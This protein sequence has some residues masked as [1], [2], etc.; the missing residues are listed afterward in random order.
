MSMGRVSSNGVK[1][2]IGQ[3]CSDFKLPTVGAEA[4]PRFTAAGHADALVTLV[5]VLEQ[6]AEDRRQRRI[7]RIRRASRLPVG[8]TWDTFEHDRVPVALRQQLD[9]LADGSFVERGVNALAF[10]EGYNRDDCASTLHLR[11]W[12]EGIRQDL[13]DRGAV[14][15]RPQPEDGQAAEELTERQKMI[16]ALGERLAG[17]VPALEDDRSPEQHARWLLANMLDWHRREDKAVWW[18]FFRLR[19]SSVEELMDERQAVAGLKFVDQVEAPGRLPVHRYSFPVQETTLRGGETLHMPGG[20]PAG[21]LVSIDVPN[22]TVDIKKRGKTADIHP[23]AVFANDIVRS[24]VLKDALVRIGKHVADNGIAGAGSYGAARDLLLREPPRLDG[25]AVRRP[26]ETPL[27]AA[28][29]IASRGSFGVLPIQGTARG[30]QDLHRGK[31]DLR[32]WCIRARVSA[33]P[34]TATK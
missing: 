12:L 15:E 16:R 2:R 28:L 7:I 9:E 17:D 1:E 30:W 5:E 31:D 13:I 6:E 10:V 20:D 4:G 24:D 26:G 3:L 29:R 11:D 27:D 22:R 8:K 21:T 32:N 18:E 25:D 19:E 34:P 23:E 14:I 33:S